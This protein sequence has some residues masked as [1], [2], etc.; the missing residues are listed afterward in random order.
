MSN[1]AYTNYSDK[2]VY[3]KYI[4]IK[5]ALLALEGIGDL[6][7]EEIIDYMARK[8]ETTGYPR[9]FRVCY[10]K[11]TGERVFNINKKLNYV[12]LNI[13]GLMMS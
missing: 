9:Q 6:R 4:Y 11:N 13:I 5:E 3:K 8:K 10:T 7:D 1:I 12:L 2:P